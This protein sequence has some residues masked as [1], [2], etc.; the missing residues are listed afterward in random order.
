MKRS[1]RVV[2]IER[3]DIEV[4]LPLLTEVL[5][6]LAYKLDNFDRLPLKETKRLLER[7]F[8]ALAFLESRM[9]IARA[10]K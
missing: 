2:E 3:G 10:S 1:S 4:L 9:L 5:N 7:R 8:T 6:D